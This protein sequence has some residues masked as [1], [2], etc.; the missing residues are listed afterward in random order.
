MNSTKQ[1]LGSENKGK[2]RPSAESSNNLRLG[3]A[4]RV[5]VQGIFRLLCFFVGYLFV[6]GV[7]A[8]V[9]KWGRL[10][11]ALLQ[12]IPYCL[13]LVGVAYSGRVLVRG[14]KQTLLM[15][16]CLVCVFTVL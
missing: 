15:V 2:D 3:L 4:D 9:F 7:L 1:A 10:T 12:F 8:E 6:V 11:D 13:V 16:S 5:A 14:D